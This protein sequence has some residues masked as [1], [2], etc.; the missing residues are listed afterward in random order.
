MRRKGRGLQVIAIDFDGVICQLPFGLNPGI[1]SSAWSS[2][3]LNKRKVPR[4]GLSRL[5]TELV[6]RLRYSIRR[7]RPGV[8]ETLRFLAREYKL[9]LVTARPGHM[10]GPTKAWLAKHELLDYFDQVIVNE[11]CLPAPLYKLEK[12]RTLGAS[13]FIEDDGRNA[14]FLSSGGIDL[15]LLVDWPKNRAD[16]P[17]A[18]QRITTL[19]GARSLLMER[20]DQSRQAR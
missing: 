19:L 3:Q 8:E 17:D 13:V 2:R 5:L 14:R 6:T 10:L 12:A 18:I 1:S 11:T 15:V 16:Y 4:E 20:A 7:P 9:A